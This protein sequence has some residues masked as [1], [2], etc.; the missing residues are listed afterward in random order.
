MPNIDPY[1]LSTV[2]PSV[3]GIVFMSAVMIY[4][5]YITIR[6][7]KECELKETVKTLKK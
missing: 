3:A 1:T 7:I 4:G 6:K 5:A 2:I